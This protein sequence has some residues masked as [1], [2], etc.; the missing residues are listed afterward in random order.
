MVPKLGHRVPE[1]GGWGLRPEIETICRAPGLGE[2]PWGSSAQPG[3]PPRWAPA[4]EGH[5]T[6][7][8][9]RLRQKPTLGTRELNFPGLVRLAR[10]SVGKTHG[11][12]RNGQGEG[13]HTGAAWMGGEGDRK[14]NRI[15]SGHFF[16]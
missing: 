16:D 8:E 9:G 3:G 14:V 15:N 10:R 11:A 5:K 6:S 7:G 1:R 13:L 2:G 12:E 4:G